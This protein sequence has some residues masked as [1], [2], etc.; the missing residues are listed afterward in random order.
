MLARRLAR[1]GRRANRSRQQARL[2]EKV[3]PAPAPHLSTLPVRLL[4]L[5]LQLRVQTMT[6]A[7][8][9]TG[10]LQL[11]APP[12]AASRAA[13][14]LGTLLPWPLQHLCPAWDPARQLPSGHARPHPTSLAS[15]PPPTPHAGL[16][17]TPPLFFVMQPARRRLPPVSWPALGS[18]STVSAGGLAAVCCGPSQHHVLHGQSLRARYLGGL[19]AESDT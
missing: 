8:C 12:A 16:A 11:P 9:A 4:P 5:P 19:H 6:N 10:E 18:F 3:L 2:Q 14:P 13:P 7:A 17:A 15:S 1:A